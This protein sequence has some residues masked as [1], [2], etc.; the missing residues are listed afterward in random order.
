MCVVC[1]DLLQQQQQETNTEGVNI[2][3]VKE[4]GRDGQKCPGSL[5]RV[6]RTKG[7]AESSQ[8]SQQL[9]YMQR[10]TILERALRWTARE[11][12]RPPWKIIV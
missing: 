10:K 9:R 2:N 11:G 3:G 8:R 12:E 4:A 1:S 7:L 6:R 5:G